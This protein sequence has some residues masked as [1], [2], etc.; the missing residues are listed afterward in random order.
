MIDPAVWYSIQGKA[1]L[2]SCVADLHS[3]GFSALT[4]CE[5]GEIHVKQGDKDYSYK[6]LRFFP[7]RKHWQGLAKVLNRTGLTATVLDD[8]VAVSW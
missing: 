4:I 1:T 3:R 8:C 6:T 5:N 7:E 2:E